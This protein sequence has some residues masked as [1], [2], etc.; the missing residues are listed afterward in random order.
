[1][2][3]DLHAHYPMHVVTDLE[4]DEGREP[5]LAL[6]RRVRKRR[7]LWGRIQGI[8][9]W[10]AMKLASDKTLDSGP[11]ISIEGMQ[12]GD[13][14]L[15]FSMLVQEF[16]EIDLSKRYAAPPSP[17]YFKTLIAEIEEVESEV[18]SHG[19]DVIRIV[20]NLEQ[21]DACLASRAIGLIHA[22]EGG[23]HLGESDEEIGRNCRALTARGVGSVTVAHLFFRQVAT[24]APAIPFLPEWLYDFLFPQ[25]G[26]DRLTP[27][28][29][30]VIRGL[31]ENRILIDLTHMD[32]GGIA[33][34]FALLDD[35]LDPGKRFPVVS[36]HAGFRFGK[37]RYMCDEGIVKKIA[38]RGGVVGLIMAQHQLNDGLRK[39][40]DYTESLAESLEI[41][42][43]HIDRIAELTGGYDHIALG[44]DFDGFIKPTMGGLDTMADLAS[45][46]TALRQKYGDEATEKM[47]SGNALGILRRLWSQPARR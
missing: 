6:M 2:W 21:L 19:E 1:M 24:N 30:A 27:R 35:E 23:Y 31:V 3:F 22:V 43:A 13:V 44:T 29:E 47:T 42:Y 20:G 11:R 32:P 33:E 37:Q 39:N 16:A 34:V 46:D 38:E 8:V 45:L 12:K 14:R 4:A 5:S 18:A 41:V 15:A 36:T 26:K 17:D 28:G 7:G 25:R 40:G 10:C 9:T